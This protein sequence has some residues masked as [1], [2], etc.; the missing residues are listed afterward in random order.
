M[1]SF[2]VQSRLA[3]V[4]LLDASADRM[5]MLWPVEIWRLRN[6]QCQR[7]SENFRCRFHCVPLLVS[8]R[9]YDRIPV[10]KQQVEVA[11][12]DAGFSELRTGLSHPLE[13]CRPRYPDPEA[14]QV[15]VRK[16]AIKYFCRGWRRLQRQPLA[17]IQRVAPP[18]WDSEEAMLDE[19]RDPFG[20]VRQDSWSKS[21]SADPSR[22]SDYIRDIPLSGLKI[23]SRFLLLRILK[24]G[25]E[26]TDLD[27]A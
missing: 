27:F 19:P 15:R 2:L 10:G 18:S 24:R 13:R 21:G 11:V 14:S 9:E 23:K 20:A 22:Y 7:A 4:D 8:N 3:C 5:T 25:K 16:V 12:L 17:S 6:L 26:R 1:E